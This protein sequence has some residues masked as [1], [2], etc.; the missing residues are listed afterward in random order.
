METDI[1]N[2][3]ANL[4]P[5]VRRFIRQ[6]HD[7][8]NNS[9]NQCNSNDGFLPETEYADPTEGCSD[10]MPSV[11]VEETQE[12]PTKHRRKNNQSNITNKRQRCNPDE[13]VAV[14]NDQ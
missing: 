1:Y 13:T 2:G 10:V 3:W 4:W 12:T 7:T 5:T 14:A 9:N 8:T 6:R 11:L